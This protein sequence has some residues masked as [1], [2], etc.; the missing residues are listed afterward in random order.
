MKVLLV[1]SWLQFTDMLNKHNLIII[2]NINPQDLNSQHYT[3]VLL[4]NQ[5]LNY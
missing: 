1:V 2:E 5:K 4:I 3:N